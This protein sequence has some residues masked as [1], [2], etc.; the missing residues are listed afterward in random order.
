MLAKR[1]E[2]ERKEVERAFGVLQ[3]KWHIISRPGRFWSAEFM[4][5]IMR[6]CIVLH[7]MC[8]EDRLEPNQMN[9]DDS[10]PSDEPAAIPMWSSADE[11][12]AHFIPHSNS[13]AALC[14]ASAFTQNEVEY[15]NTRRLLLN[16]LWDLEGD[17]SEH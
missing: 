13:L 3:S 6:C 1:Q 14:A 2:G 12:S 9:E 17:A 5:K 7:N 4:E 16:H 10:L 8:V 11:N 15:V